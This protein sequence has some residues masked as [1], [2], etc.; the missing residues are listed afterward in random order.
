MIPALIK[1]LFWASKVRFS[2]WSNAILLWPLLIIFAAVENTRSS[3]KQNYPFLRNEFLQACRSWARD[4]SSRIRCPRGCVTLGSF[5]VA[6][7]VRRVWWF[8]AR[9]DCDGLGLTLSSREPLIAADWRSASTVIL[10]HFKWTRV[11][12]GSFSMNTRHG[13]SVCSLILI[14]ASIGL[15]SALLGK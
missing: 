1:S 7:W 15:T 9:G 13:R 8:G 3:G 4:G 11:M 10:V 6:S 14:S 5:E 2:K 12:A